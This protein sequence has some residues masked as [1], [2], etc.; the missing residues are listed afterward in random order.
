MIR[1]LIPPP[2]VALVIAL[3]ALAGCGGGDARYAVEG[4]PVQRAGPWLVELDPEPPGDGRALLLQAR[5]DPALADSLYP[6]TD[7]RLEI[8]S[9]SVTLPDQSLVLH[10]GTARRDC[11]LFGDVDDEFSL[12]IELAPLGGGVFRR[13]DRQWRRL[14]G[15]A[16]RARMR[17]WRYGDEPLL[18]VPGAGETTMVRADWLG[19]GDGDAPAEAAPLTRAELR[20]ALRSLRSAGHILLTEPLPVLGSRPRALLRARA[21]WLG[22]PDGEILGRRVLTFRLGRGGG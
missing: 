1:R 8:D 9:L 12:R 7:V 17:A 5:F 18:F 22:V 15:A 2:P 14:E 21:T 19:C 13:I 16:A 4:E 10:P 11:T 6:F 3:A 20:G